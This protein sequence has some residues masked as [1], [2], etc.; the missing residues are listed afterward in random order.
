MRRTTARALAALAALAVMLA[1]IACARVP[2]ARAGTEE[3]STFDPEASEHDDE[4]LL[5]RFLNRPQRAWRDE[6]ERAPQAFRTSQGC[7]DAGV[8]T[9]NSDLKLRAPLG[10]HAEF[11]LKLRERETDAESF[12]YM[13]F[14]FR[15]PTARWG[16]P[17]AW[18]RPFADKRRQDF[19]ITYDLGADT[20]AE[21]VRLTFGLED[22]FNNLWA[23]RQTAV[24]SNNA[25]PY[26]SRPY[27]P[28]IEWTSRHEH[29]RID[30][31]GR[32]LTPSRKR[33]IDWSDRANDQVATLWGTLAHASVELDLAGC[34][35]TVATDNEQ[36]AS[37]DY[38]VGAAAGNGAFRRRRWSVETGLRRALTPK[39]EA[40]ATYLY[41]VRDTRRAPP[42][43]PATFGAVD[44]LVQGELRW[45]PHPRIAGRAGGMYDRITIGESGPAQFH[46]NTEGTRNESRGYLGLDV[47]FGRVLVSGVEGIELDP[48]PYPVWAWHDKGFLAMQ[49]TF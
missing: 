9:I 27:E 32:W 43:G 26:R 17:G 14:G 41:Q 13:D 4:S 49:T 42:I 22:M 35:W 39:L 15:F 47:R 25:E 16:T 46:P 24:G 6:W 18:F 30:V 34:E 2:A 45:Q 28:A 10:T 40:S 8:W 5:D 23:F 36:A 33:V 38:V 29:V 11:G 12:D 19:G 44:R 48:E 37:S 20:T 7:I 31:E 21:H 1:G 3:W